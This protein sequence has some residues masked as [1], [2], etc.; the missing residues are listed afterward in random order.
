MRKRSQA[1]GRQVVVILGANI[2]EAGRLATTIMAT[3]SV[4]TRSVLIFNFHCLGS[5]AGII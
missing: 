3:L 5:H 2:M 4:A 1:A